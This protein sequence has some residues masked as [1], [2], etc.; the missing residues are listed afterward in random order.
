MPVRRGGAHHSYFASR[1]S[2]N[3]PRQ[4]QHQSMPRNTA[5]FLRDL[6]WRPLRN[7][8]PAAHASVEAEVEDPMPDLD[9]VEIALDHPCRRHSAACARRFRSGA[10]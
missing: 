7:H 2:P 3:L 6:L 9:D 10:R 8:L 5:F 1:T 4:H